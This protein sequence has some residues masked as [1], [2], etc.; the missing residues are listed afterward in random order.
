MSK[1][2]SSQSNARRAARAAGFELDA[3]EIFQDGGKFGF[4]PLTPATDDAADDTTDEAGLN[5]LGEPVAPPATGLV[6]QDIPAPPAPVGEATGDVAPVAPARMVVLPVRECFD[7]LSSGLAEPLHIA[8]F[9]FARNSQA[10]AIK[11]VQ[12]FAKKLGFDGML[13]Q[14][15]EPDGVIIPAKGTKAPKA[16]KAPRAPKAPKAPR[17]PSALSPTA[18]LAVQ[19]ASQPGGTT[20]AKMDA[21]AGKSLPWTQILKTAAERLGRTLTIAK[22]DGRATYT[23]AS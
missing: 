16:D 6:D 20:R 10:D 22:V 23:L 4:R 19:L 1:L 21:A 8:S 11:A 2:F 5:D 12:V 13:H 15:G 9:V 3:V 7:V 17:D 14:M 18:T